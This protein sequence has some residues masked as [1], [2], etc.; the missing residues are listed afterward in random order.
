MKS[1]LAAL[2]TA[3]LFLQPQVP[4][5]RTALPGYRYE[6]PR[7]NFSHPDFQT[8]W[9][10]YTGNLKSADGRRFGFELTFFR[11]AV[12][13]DTSKIAAWD[14]RDLFLAHLALSDLDGAHFYHNERINRAGPGI[15]GVDEASDRIWN[16]NWQVQWD[17]P[18]QDLRAVEERFSLRFAMHPEK[19]PVIHGENGVSSKAAGEGHASHYIS[20]TRL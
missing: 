12:N 11:Q 7:D 13:R 4:P 19:L 5:Y 3:L 10:Y 17:G 14:V 2:C 16:G 18:D 9:W 8:E 1:K 20:F 15:A 6:F